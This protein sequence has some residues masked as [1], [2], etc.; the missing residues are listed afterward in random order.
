MCILQKSVLDHEEKINSARAHVA[1]VENMTRQLESKTS[2]AL[3]PRV[4]KL[5]CSNDS[6]LFIKAD[7]CTSCGMGFKTE[8]FQCVCMLECKHVYHLFC[9][10]YLCYKE[11][12]CVAKGCD[13]EIPANA[14][15]LVI[16]A[17]GGGGDTFEQTNSEFFFTQNLSPS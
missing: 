11:Q 14:K 4:P 3:L 13:K 7:A 8:D 1:L 12:H 15:K 6:T 5:H 17:I 2:M 16:G 10:T 9:F